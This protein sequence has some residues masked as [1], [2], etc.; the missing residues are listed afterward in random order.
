MK[1]FFKKYK[2]LIYIL[3]F[4]LLI[5]GA[6]LVLKN[7]LYPDDLISIYG[8]RLNGVEKIKI[9][10]NRKLA[11]KNGYATDALI[12]TVDVDLRGKI[13][14]IIVKGKEGYTE[15]IAKKSLFENLTIL[16]DKE[17]QNYDIQF[18]VTNETLKYSMIGYKYKTSDIIVWSEYREVTDENKEG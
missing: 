13:I 3:F 12:S 8:S 1:L 9:D 16:K 2:T 14:N 15:I 4:V 10:S 7:F 17:K 11:I 5:L 18:F 6:L